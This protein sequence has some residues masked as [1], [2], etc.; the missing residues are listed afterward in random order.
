[1]VTPG[2]IWAFINKSLEK[3]CTAFVIGIELIVFFNVFF[4]YVLNN[5]LS[6]GE[7]LVSILIFWITFLGAGLAVLQRKHMKMSLLELF[8]PESILKIIEH[9]ISL[10]SMGF[11]ALLFH[12]GLKMI[13]LMGH[14]PTELLRWPFFT[15][16]AAIPIGASIMFINEILVIKRRITDPD[17]KVKKEIKV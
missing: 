12:S 13:D 14:R 8:L 5:P 1:M 10:L 4:R 9:I 7:E 16:F 11:L 15:V 3:I 6:W 17:Y 2:D